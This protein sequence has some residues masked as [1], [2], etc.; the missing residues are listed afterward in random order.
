MFDTEL[1]S[2]VVPEWAVKLLK[3]IQIRYTCE[4]LCSLSKSAIFTSNH[5]RILKYVWNFTTVDYGARLVTLYRK[6]IMRGHEKVRRGHEIVMRGH[7]IVN[8]W[9]RQNS[10]LV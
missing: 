3:I 5:N 7:E 6:K 8:V 9:P 10:P 4:K 2:V 1:K